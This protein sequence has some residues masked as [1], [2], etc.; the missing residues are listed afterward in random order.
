MPTTVCSLLNAGVAGIIGPTSEISTM[1]IRSVCDALEIPHLEVHYDIEARSD[2]LTINLHPRPEVLARA[3]SDLNRVLG[4]ED[5]AVVYDYNEEVL[6]F[7]GVLQQ[8]RDKGWNVQ[9][10][11]LNHNKPFRE[12]FWQVQ[13]DGKNN[14]VL[15]VK[16][17]NLR[18][19]LRHVSSHRSIIFY[20]LP[21]F[22]ISECLVSSLTPLTLLPPS[23]WLLFSLHS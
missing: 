2:A 1:H 18:Q 21:I 7:S 16:Q 13:E 4:W 11:Q 10:Y 3:F 9:L 8:A 19:A 20:F 17:H 23:L 12:T 6:L 5:F 14:I 22:I 15:D